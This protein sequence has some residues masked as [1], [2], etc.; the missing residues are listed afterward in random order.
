MLPD[1]I[2]KGGGVGF[3]LAPSCS[4]CI[5][6]WASPSLTPTLVLGRELKAFG[7]SVGGGGEVISLSLFLPIDVGRKLS[8]PIKGG[9]F[10]GEGQRFFLAASCF[11]CGRRTEGCGR[12]C[13]EEGKEGVGVGVGVGGV[14][15]VIGGSSF[16]STMWEELRA[17]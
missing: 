1:E 8:F 2:G 6:I 17:L 4:R 14:C 11:L 13:V 12:Y 15:C 9:V 10:W 3:S 7:K 16:P 5:K